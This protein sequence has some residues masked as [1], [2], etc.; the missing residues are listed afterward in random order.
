M[1]FLK[2]SLFF[3]TPAAILVL[4]ASCGNKDSSTA[5]KT[6]NKNKVLN[7]EGFVVR[8]VTFQNNYTT[9]GT[10]LPN[11]EVQILPEVSGRVTNIY[12]KEGT[13][14][15]KGQML[16]KLYN[17]DIKAQIQKLQ[18][19]KE[20]QIKIKERQAE[21]LRIGGISQQD[22]ETTATGI[23]SI[24]ADIAVAQAQLR[25]TVIYAP[26]PGRIGIRNI[27][28]GA[29]I[30]P[31]TLIATLQQTKILKMDFTIPDQYK[32]EVPMNKKVYFTVNGNLDTFSGTITALEPRAD[33][34]TRTLKV[35]AMVENETHTLGAG[36]FTHVIIP[37][38]DDRNALLIPSQAII[39]TT[40]D[41]Q[42]AIVRNGKAK[43]VT[44]LI[45]ARTND[46]V[47]I[48][49]GLH[50]G[51]TILITGIMQVKDGMNVKVSKIN[52]K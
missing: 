31:S 44:V 28:E 11:E 45:G 9:S 13:H 17:D 4:S 21:L 48:V 1:T 30:T 20:L 18:A 2:T 6:D 52:N 42:A 10:L 19:Q 37:F 14:V 29:V 36:S 26:F 23:Q 5:A 46:K 38:T 40:R 16:V 33:A 43:L 51:D 12:F 41:K 49:Q 50:A 34:V 27:S 32:Q 22:Y 24:D 8:P 39:P 25:K 7:A 15:E 35:R 3:L 47:E